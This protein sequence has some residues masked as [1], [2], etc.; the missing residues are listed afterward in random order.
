MFH[1]F[2]VQRYKTYKLILPSSTF[3]ST[4]FPLPVVDIVGSPSQEHIL[5]VDCRTVPLLRKV[6]GID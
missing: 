2:G 1:G 5:L 6:E 4:V 3:N